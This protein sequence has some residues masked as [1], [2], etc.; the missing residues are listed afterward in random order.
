MSPSFLVTRPL[1][2]WRRCNDHLTSPLFPS[3][4][5]SSVHLLYPDFEPLLQKLE[6][7]NPPAFKQYLVGESLHEA[8]RFKR[9]SLV[10]LLEQRFAKSE[11]LEPTS[12]PVKACATTA[13]AHASSNA[14]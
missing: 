8:K 3:F 1:L 5:P 14:H 13:A 12:S 10:S 9:K 7:A 11:T 6:Q 2:L 4:L